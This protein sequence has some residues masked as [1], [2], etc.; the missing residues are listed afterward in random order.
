MSNL[1]KAKGALEPII[2]KDEKKTERVNAASAQILAGAL[3]AIPP[4]QA[5]PDMGTMAEKAFVLEETEAPAMPVGGGATPGR[6]TASRV[7]NL[8]NDLTAQA[9]RYS[10]EQQRLAQDRMK[11]RKLDAER[12]SKDQN[13]TKSTSVWLPPAAKKEMLT[14]QMRMFDHDVQVSPKTLVLYALDKLRLM[15][16]EDAAKELKASNRDKRRKEFRDA[17]TAAE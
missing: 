7:D 6:S 15:P 5:A 11:K 13:T 3:T 12:E 4:V 14:L 9:E 16:D 10:S 8:K 2:T 1:P 17:L